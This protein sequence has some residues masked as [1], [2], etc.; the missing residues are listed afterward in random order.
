[1]RT[2]MIQLPLHD[3]KAPRWLVERMKNLSYLITKAIVLEHGHGTLLERLSDPLWFQAF[4]CVLG[5]DWHSSGVTTVVTGVL[6][7]ALAEHAYDL[8]VMVAGGKGRNA[9]KASNEIVEICDAFGISSS[10]TNELLYASRMAAKVDNTLLQDGHELYHHAFIIAE[11]GRWAVVQQGMDVNARTAR[12]YHWLNAKGFVDEPRSGIIGSSI[13]A[14]VLDMTAK[15]S[16]ECRRVC[17]DIANDSNTVSSVQL[18][19]KQSTLD[20]WLANNNNNATTYRDVEVYAMPK[21]IDWS[22]FKRIYDVHP[23]NYEELIAVRGVGAGTVRAL[24][25]IAELIYGA[26][27]SWRDPV[28]FTF[29][30]GG[31]DGVPYPVD[32]RTYDESIRVLKEAIEGLDVDDRMRKDMLVRLARSSILA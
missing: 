13:L 31:K 18:L 27:A 11:D 17:V 12:R 5:Y 19:Y 10:K 3:G 14:N 7:H 25:L 6:K 30:H 1:M 2:G 24:A 20:T 29:A 4:G 21:H 22:I 9:L 8:G 26:R 23:R 15:E 28:R 32:R 16:E